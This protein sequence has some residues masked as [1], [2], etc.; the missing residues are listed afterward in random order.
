MVSSLLSTSG[1]SRQAHC[2]GV[3][4]LLPHRCAQQL[5]DPTPQEARL[6]QRE[7]LTAHQ[8]PALECT[9]SHSPIRDSTGGRVTRRG[10]T[11]HFTE[12][13]M[14]PRKCG[15]SR[16]KSDCLGQWGSVDEQS[17]LLILV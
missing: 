4:F 17:G 13:H 11:P 10:D 2:A 12:G 5:L 6:L 16:E 9:S 1:S 15:E 3:F 7:T 8:L 14:E